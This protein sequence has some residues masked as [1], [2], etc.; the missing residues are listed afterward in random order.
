[1]GPGHEAPSAASSETENWLLE[2]EIH[3]LEDGQESQGCMVML[4]RTQILWISE[5]F[6][7]ILKLVI[8]SREF[9]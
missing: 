2:K 9:L 8:H 4:S 7:L 5:L 3:W 6:G 1:M